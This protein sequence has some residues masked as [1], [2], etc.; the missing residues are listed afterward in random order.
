MYI[1]INFVCCFVSGHRHIV[2]AHI[3]KVTIKTNGIGCNITQ[4]HILLIE[5]LIRREN[6]YEET[7]SEIQ[8]EG[9]TEREMIIIITIRLR[10]RDYDSIVRLLVCVLDK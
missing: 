2:F 8:K 1:N 3:L 7:E 5:R 6:I 4:T 10:D 9:E